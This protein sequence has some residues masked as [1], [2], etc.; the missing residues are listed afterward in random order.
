LDST[1]A[2]LLEQVRRPDNTVAWERF[3]R[4]YTP[5]L[6]S[7]AKRQGLQDQDCADLVQDVFLAL[8]RVMPYFQYDP[9]RSFRSWLG[10]LTWNRLK[11]R[12]RQ[13][14]ALPIAADNPLWQVIHTSSEQEAFDEDEYRRVLLTRALGIVES[15]SNPVTW[16]L[17]LATVLQSHSPADTASKFHVTL[18][19]VYLARSRTLRRLKEVVTGLLD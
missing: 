13:R 3:V 11:D 14:H 6:L 12:L 18:N 7:F 5:L 19:A 9:N 15:E 1:P 8:V 4:L 10:T 2:T 16:Q 17:F